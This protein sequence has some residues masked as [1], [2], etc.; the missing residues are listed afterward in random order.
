[1][2]AAPALTRLSLLEQACEEASLSGETARGAL[3]GLV[4]REP[5]AREAVTLAEEAYR[6]AL[7]ALGAHELGRPE[8]ASV[9]PHGVAGLRSPKALSGVLGGG[10]PLGRRMRSCWAARRELRAAC[11]TAE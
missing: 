10:L 7:A 9:T 3:A 5:A 11:A 1:M 4:A 8:L 2:E 6:A